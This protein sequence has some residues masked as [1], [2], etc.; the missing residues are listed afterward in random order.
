MNIGDD[1]RG[2]QGPI[3][4]AALGFVDGHR[5]RHGADGFLGVWELA[6]AAYEAGDPPAS[7]TYVL[8]PIPGGVQFTVD[9]VDVKAG[10]RHLVFEVAFGDKDGI[11]MVRDGAVLTTR[12]AGGPITEADRHLSEDLREMRIIQRGLQADGRPFANTTRYVRRAWFAAKAD[13]VG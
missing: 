4:L 11:E 8:A 10:A 1:G 3:V 13:S 12:A 5:P 6:D 2:R 7:A 9:W